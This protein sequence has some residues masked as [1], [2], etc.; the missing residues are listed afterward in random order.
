[1]EGLKTNDLFQTS[2]GVGH[3]WRPGYYFPSNRHQVKLSTV[4]G[5]TANVKFRVAEGDRV[6]RRG[7]ALLGFTDR[8][9]HS[10]VLRSN[11]VKRNVSYEM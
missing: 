3:H 2:S 1:V 4:T 9:Q 10:S 11:T 5:H 8:R 6:W 7:I